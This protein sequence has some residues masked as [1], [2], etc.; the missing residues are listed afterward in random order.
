VKELRLRNAGGISAFTFESRQFIA[1]AG[2]FLAILPRLDNL[3][4]V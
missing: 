1:Q 2:G 4:Q 3:A